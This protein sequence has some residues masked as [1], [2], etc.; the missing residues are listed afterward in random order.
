[1]LQPYSPQKTKKPDTYNIFVI[2]ISDKHNVEEEERSQACFNPAAQS[3]SLRLWP[4]L[5]FNRTGILW[6]SEQTV[7]IIKKF[8]PRIPGWVVESLH[9]LPDGLHDCRAGP[10]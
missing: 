7:N 6:Q 3:A 8:F 1:M 5:F 4:K 2:N 10:R 9:D